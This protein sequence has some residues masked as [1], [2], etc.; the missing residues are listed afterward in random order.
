MLMVDDTIYYFVFSSK[1]L[2]DKIETEKK[3]NRIY[4][5]KQVRVNGRF[6][7]YTERITD[8]KNATYSDAKLITSGKFSDMII[9]TT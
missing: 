9:K 4:V 2:K 8:V 3:I 1:Q 7:Q 5:P 6:Q